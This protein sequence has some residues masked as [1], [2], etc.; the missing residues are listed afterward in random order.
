MWEV[1]GKDLSMTEGDYGVELPITVNDITFSGNDVLSV[2][3]VSASS[4][5]AILTKVY[6][7]VQNQIKLELTEAESALLPVGYYLYS[8]DW[9]Q[10]G[11]FMC[12]LVPMS[13]LKV[14]KKA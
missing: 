13:L 8:L 9:Y 10:N 3:I 2:K 14:V 11:V 5:S 1:K 4:G 7:P 12:N 6:T